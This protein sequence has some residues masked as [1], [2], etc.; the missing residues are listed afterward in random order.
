MVGGHEHLVTPLKR[1]V[2][3]TG[4]QGLNLAQTE[5][6]A[7]LIQDQNTIAVPSHGQSGFENERA[8]CP[9]E[10]SSSRNFSFGWKMHCRMPASPEGSVWNTRKPGSPP[11][12]KLCSASC[13]AKDS[14]VEMCFN[15]SAKSEQSGIGMV[16][17]C[18]AALMALTKAGLSARTS[19]PSMARRK[20][21]SLRLSPRALIRE[22]P[23]TC[24]SG[25]IC[26]P[27][28]C[29]SM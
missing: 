23:E 2:L 7:R 17:G 20:A 14:A 15:Q 8:I 19:V 13:V 26:P 12:A 4:E 16:T 24:Q 6:I 28:L 27:S 21:I 9:D 11:L 3:K 25:N 18:F 10:S 1:S 22:I 29:E 5:E